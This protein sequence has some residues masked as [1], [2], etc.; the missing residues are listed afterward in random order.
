MSVTVHHIDADWNNLSSFIWSTTEYNLED[1]RAPSI[2]KCYLE[3]V[4]DAPFLLV[5]TDNTNTMP[6]AFYLLDSDDQ[7]GC[8]SHISSLVAKACV[9]S[10]EAAEVKLNVE[11]AKKLVEHVKR[12]ELQSKLTTT[13]KQ[14]IGR[15]GKNLKTFLMPGMSSNI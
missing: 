8:I 14:T 15:A 6:A 1:H 10:D 9:T 3:N 4:P 5:T 7:I 13:L 12:T 11:A 2:S